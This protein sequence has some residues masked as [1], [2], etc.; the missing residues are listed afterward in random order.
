MQ[1]LTLEQYWKFHTKVYLEIAKEKNVILSLKLHTN[2]SV[3]EQWY[4]LSIK[5]EYTDPES[6]HMKEEVISEINTIEDMEKYI[7]MLVEKEESFIVQN[8][9]KDLYE[10]ILYNIGNTEEVSYFVLHELNINLRKSTKQKILSNYFYQDLNQMMDNISHREDKIEIINYYLKKIKGNKHLNKLVEMITLK[11]IL[12]EKFKEK[13]NQFDDIFQSIFNLNEEEVVIK[14]LNKEDNIDTLCDW[15]SLI[16]NKEKGISLVNQLCEVIDINKCSNITQVKIRDC[17]INKF[18]EAM[19]TFS[20]I[21]LLQP[22]DI[23]KIFT[24]HENTTCLSLII[25]IKE[26]QKN[27]AFNNIEAESYIAILNILKNSLK[28]CQKLKIEDIYCNS[29]ASNEINVEKWIVVINQDSPITQFH[30]K[31]VIVDMIDIHMRNLVENKKDIT[32]WYK[33]KLNHEDLMQWLTKYFFSLK[34]NDD[35]EDKDS[36]NR[37]KI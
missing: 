14:L 18:P 36:T 23:N 34:L 20:W 29:I 30:L 7:P 15:I 32:D 27:Y 19:A 11:K 16:E 13:V 12:N 28:R 37:N 24:S 21:H 10:K 9:E 3:K 25:N 4:Q 31:N 1:E 8:K 22:N 2:T 33:D 35:L 26:L 17:L 5:K 6:S